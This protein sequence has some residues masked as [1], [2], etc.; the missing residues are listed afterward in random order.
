MLIF[1]ARV[2]HEL[3]LLQ[4]M[5]YDSPQWKPLMK[6][7]VKCVISPDIDSLQLKEEVHD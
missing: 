4:S 7:K 1:S 6:L 3:R 5:F 2:Q